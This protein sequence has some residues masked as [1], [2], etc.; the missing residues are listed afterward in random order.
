MGR[1][2][3]LPA[4]S[5]VYTSIFRDSYND[6]ARRERIFIS[7][8]AAQIRIALRYYEFRLSATRRIY[9]STAHAPQW[10]GATQTH[11]PL[12]PSKSV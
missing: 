10:R 8:K 2:C 3:R 9:T 11:F 7:A 12:R 4:T 1:F 6:T 5:H